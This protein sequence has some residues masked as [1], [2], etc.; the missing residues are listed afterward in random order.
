MEN[1]DPFN[2]GQARTAEE[3]ADL[4]KQRVL[5]DAQLVEE[6]ADVTPEG[7]IVNVTQE[8]NQV[9]NTKV[10]AEEELDDKAR[11]KARLEVFEENILDQQPG[12]WRIVA[13]TTNLGEGFRQIDTPPY[14]EQIKVITLKQGD[15]IN[16]QSEHES[17]KGMIHIKVVNPEVKY[18]EKG[19]ARWYYLQKQTLE[20]KKIKL[21]GPDEYH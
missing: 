8:G 9:Y 12:H 17:D 6:G 13:E 10:K 14:R 18:G 20:G 5:S 21:Q 4:A 15:E 19:R 7:K 16:V 1:F 11:Q 3:L 2:K